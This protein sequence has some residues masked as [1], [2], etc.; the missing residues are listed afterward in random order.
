MEKHGN[1]LQDL[2]EAVLMASES[3]STTASQIQAK[4]TEKPSLEALQD[5]LIGLERDG[6]L[7]RRDEECVLTDQG[8]VIAQDTLRRHRL[9]EML[10]FSLLGLDRELASDIGCQVEH[11]VRAEMLDG[12]CTLLG[13]PSHCPHGNPIPPGPC[14]RSGRATVETQVVPLTELKPGERGRVVYIKPRD[15]QRLH[16]LS[17]LGLNPG[18]EIEL[19]RR[20][21][22]FCLH[23]E[24]TD[25]AIDR[26]VAEDIQV[27][28]LG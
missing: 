8:L 15:H 7:T 9:T 21:P 13:H 26:N 24:G 17:A 11:G 23:F 10:L 25:L 27:S 4:L 5:D 3:G 6:L 20:K 12:V 28:R 2:L 14:C 1:Y 16:K 22:A 18:V 19:H